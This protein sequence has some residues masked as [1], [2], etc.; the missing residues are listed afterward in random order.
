[1]TSDPSEANLRIS[2][3][4]VPGSFHV[5]LLSSK[6]M[7]NYCAMNKHTGENRRTTN[8]VLPPTISVTDLEKYPV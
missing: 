4:R 3:A 2:V 6:P 8:P 1:M 5:D 7:K